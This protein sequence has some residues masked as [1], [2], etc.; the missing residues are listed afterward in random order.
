MFPQNSSQNGYNPNN[1]N[2]IDIISILSF[3]LG[4]ENLQEN[5]EQSAHN[6]VQA[7]NDNQANYLLEKIYARFEE[8]DKLLR[9]ILEAVKSHELQ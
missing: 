8:Q 1:L 4:L 7:A 5:R 3:L 2:V 6:D 9:E